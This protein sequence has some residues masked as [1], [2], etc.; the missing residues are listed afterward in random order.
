MFAG[1]LTYNI[2][3]SDAEAI[4]PYLFKGFDPAF[5][6]NVQKGD[7]IIAGDN[8]GCGSS[9]EHPSVGLAHAGVKA[10]IVKSVNR[11][12][13]RSAINQGLILIVHPEAVDSYREGDRVDVNFLGGKIIIEEKQF[14]FAPLP[15]KLMD[16][17][18]KKGLVN[19]VK[20]QK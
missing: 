19:W 18:S 2:L 4:M 12:F 7:V 6:E 11:I 8:F 14:S 1:N 13:Y 5:S 15:D 20:A 9:R 17:I 10:I 3:S 16:I